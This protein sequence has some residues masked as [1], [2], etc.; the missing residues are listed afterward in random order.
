MAEKN[1][2]KFMALI[3]PAKDIKAFYDEN[4][5]Y[6]E[7]LQNIAVA[8]ADFRERH[9]KNRDNDYIIVN[10][11]ELYAE[12]VW[13]IILAGETAKAKELKK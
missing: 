6:I 13:D 9:G 7:Q 10:Q 1:D 3:I 5:A 12:K 8:Y 11:D 4:P 2:Y